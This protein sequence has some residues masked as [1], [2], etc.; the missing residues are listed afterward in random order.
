LSDAAI[1]SWPTPDCAKTAASA[2]SC[3]TATPDSCER[4][5]SAAALW[6]AFSMN[7]AIASTVKAAANFFARSSAKSATS[8]WK[9]L[10]CFVAADS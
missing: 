1:S 2:D 7:S 6:I 4:R 5:S 8:L 9:A 10:S 3:S